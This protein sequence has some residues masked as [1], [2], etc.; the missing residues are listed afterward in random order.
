[1]NI[2][3]Q[4][5]HEFIGRHIGPNEQETEQMLSV[6][7]VKSIGELI[8]KTLPENIRLREPL[9]V[10]EPVNEHQY[11]EDLRKTA[12]KNKV[13]K[14]YIGQGYYDTITPSVILRNLFENP[15]WYTQYTPYQAEI[16]QGRLESLLNFQTMVSDLT[17]LPIANASLLDE[18]TAAAEAM[19]MLY[20]N[21]NKG[22]KVTANKFFVDIKIFDQTKD[23]LQTR[24][25]PIKIELVFGD[26]SNVRLDETYFGAIVQYPDADGSIED[27]RSFIKSVQAVNAHVVMATDLLALTLLTPPGE[28]GADVAIGSSQ[29]FGVPMGFG[30]PHAAFFATKDEFKRIIPG[31]IIGI[32]IDAQGNRALRMALQTREQ[33]IRREKATS[34]ICT[35]QALLANMAAMYAVYHGAEGL[36]NIAKRTSM[37]ALALDVELREMGYNQVNQHYFDTLKVQVED[38][39]ALKAIAE[40]EHINFKYLDNNFVCI[41]LDETTAQCDVL[42]IL[43]VFAVSLGLGDAGVM[44]SYD[45]HLQNIPTSLT[46]TSNFCYTRYLTV[47]TA[48][49]K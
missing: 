20:N 40:S 6:I 32:S 31:R 7:G 47:I 38:S 33:H 34:N 37:L 26:H 43:H 12:D 1:M 13:L 11:L 15:G 29:R 10:P 28:L 39:D 22:E 19:A 8:D 18:G 14:S 49:L 45:T 24:A 27:Y 48:K 41:S 25:T 2:F 44:F 42:N 17:G 4:Q 35:A 3:E 9:D 23:V 36:K 5:A 30:G 46:R 16:A 21:K